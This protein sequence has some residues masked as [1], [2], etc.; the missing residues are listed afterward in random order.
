MS[1]AET[2]DVERLRRHL[3]AMSAV[4]RQLHA[5]LE[6]GTVRIAEG[7][8]ARQDDPLGT[9]EGLDGGIGAITV[10]RTSVASA[11]LEQLQLQGGGKPSLVRSP[12]RGMFV[13]EGTLRRQIKSGLIFLALAR[14]FG[15]PRQM[16]DAE[17]ERLEEGLRSRCSRAARVRRS[18]L[19][20]VGAGR[21]VDFLCPTS[22]P[23]A[24]CW[25]CRRPRS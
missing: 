7:A 2:P 18:S 5:Q 1:A 23:L 25:P 8:G 24:R 14:V 11:W 21:F 12:K 9:P 10:R 22:S 15:E 17:L 16:R 4:N 6:G 13:V 20:A 3:R 19:S